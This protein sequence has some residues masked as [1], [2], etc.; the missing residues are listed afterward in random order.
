MQH[1]GPGPATE[2]DSALVR[3]VRNSTE[4]F[5]DV[6]VAIKGGELFGHRRELLN[7]HDTP[8]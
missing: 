7:R 6:S 2:Q 5:R 3:M 1:H 8:R 4:R